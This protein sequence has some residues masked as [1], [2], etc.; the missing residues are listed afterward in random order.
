MTGVVRDPKLGE[1]VQTTKY[2]G[3]GIFAC[4]DIHR[5]KVWL[6]NLEKKTRRGIAVSRDFAIQDIYILPCHH[7]NFVEKLR[8]NSFEISS[9]EIVN[10]FAEK[11]KERENF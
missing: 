11:E 3:D 1:W 5:S 6:L 2:M 8:N 4:L 9:T 7:P 10:C